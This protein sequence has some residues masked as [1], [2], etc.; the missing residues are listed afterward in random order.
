MVKDKKKAGNKAAV[1]AAKAAKQEKKAGKKDKKVA[2]KIQEVDSDAEDV[3]LDAVL[4][5]YA[6]EQ[7][8]F[9]A[10]TEVPSE[11]PAARTSAT[12]IASPANENEL[13][14][15]GGEYFNGATAKFFNDLLVYNIKQDSWKK[16]TSPNSPLPRSGHAWCRGANTKDIYLFGGEFSSPKQG[17]FYHY[18]DFWKLDPTEREWT[19]IESKGKASAPPARSGHRMVGYK[20]YVI[21]FGGFQDTSATTKYLNDLWIYDCVNF[22][23]HSPKLQAARAV[24]DARSSFTLLPHDQGAV[25]YGGYSRVKT[26][27]GGKQQQQGKG[28]KSSGGGPANRM[29]LKPKVHD[30]SW[31]L[32]ITPPPADVAPATLPAVSWEKRKKPA[33][34]PNP[35]RAG[36]TMAYHKGRGVLFGGVHDVEDSEEAIDSEFFNQAFVWNI[37][38][39]RYVPLTLRR[40]KTNANKKAAQQANVSRRARGK[41]DEEEL[42]ANLKALEMKAGAASLDSDDEQP[43]KDEPE[44]DAVEKIEK[45]R[46]YEFPHPRF[47][48]ALTVQGDNLYIFGG[49]YEKGDREYTFDEMWSVNL[50]HL[51]G[52]VEIFKRELE[53]WQGSDDEADSEDDED[54]SEDEEESGDEDDAS[55]APTSVT[56]SPAIAPVE[57][58]PEEEISALTDTLPHPRPFE[59]LREFYARTS[60]AWQNVII[61]DLAFRG[62][63]GEKSPKE[64]KKLAFERSEEKWWD[65]REEIRALEDEQ[66]A[67]GIGEVVSLADKEGSG[68]GVG[69]RR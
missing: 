19:R 4:A 50:N 44:E 15:F 29:V 35:L 63:T 32:R 37:E 69:R 52:V 20:Q 39:N 14:L 61:D 3:D 58:A 6:K 18:N 23:W 45:P 64:I 48:A 53:D 55:T 49:T 56:D 41:A 42:L 66:E 5:Q 25:I 11:P 26:A 34:A 16:V 60:E 59:S 24:P 67:A 51:D 43:K 65:C 21:L 30:D 33:N 7:E 2:G 38:R 68:G 57:E 8:Q 46:T 27:A 17:T 9:L 36:A 54:D 47:N 13:F 12:I 1:K 40:P 22:T 31:Y 10:I 28:K 62:K